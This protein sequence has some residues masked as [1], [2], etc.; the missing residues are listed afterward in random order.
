MVLGWD[1]SNDTVHCPSVR[2]LECVSINARNHGSRESE[3]NAISGR[4]K[5]QGT[6]I[7]IVQ[8]CTGDNTI[9]SMVR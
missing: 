3:G 1:K 2:V 9:E 5:L 7:A 4:T 6:V 8:V